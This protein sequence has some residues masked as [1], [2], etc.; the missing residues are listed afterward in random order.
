MVWNRHIERIS[1]DRKTAYGSFS[2]LDLVAYEES[3]NRTVAS[4]ISTIDNV[5]QVNLTGKGSAILKVVQRTPEIAKEEFA[6]AFSNGNF[7][8]IAGPEVQ[9]S[10]TGTPEVAA[11]AKVTINCRATNTGR[12]PLTGAT[13]KLTGP[14]GFSAT[15]A[16][17]FAI[18]SP[19]DTLNWKIDMTTSPSTRGNV[20][21]TVNFEGSA[22]GDIFGIKV[23]LTVSVR[24]PKPQ[25]CTPLVTPASGTVL[26]SYLAQSFTVKVQFPRYDPTEPGVCSYDA[27]ETSGWF[28]LTGR[29]S[30]QGEGEF[31]VNVIQN[32]KNSLQTI[33]DHQFRLMPGFDYHFKQYHAK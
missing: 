14:A 23:P 32:N 20:A 21:Y 13:L 30:G 31:Q 6:L 24:A 29:K 5:E 7:E 26:L 27:W 17:N 28:T 33:R 15:P 19:T 16:A 1:A 8:E 22:F 9:I 4:S 25:D 11:G 2:N 10:C 12:L 18:F 3:T